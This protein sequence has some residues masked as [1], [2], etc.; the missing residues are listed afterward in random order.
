[1][2][3]STWLSLFAFAG[4]AAGIIC[5]GALILLV[6]LRRRTLGALLVRFGLR[7]FSPIGFFTIVILVFLIVSV[8]ESGQF[9]DRTITHHA[10]SGLLG[11]ALA[12]GF[13][14]I[15]VV[16]MQAR[17]NAVRMRDDRGQRLNLIGVII[18]ASVSAFAN[19]AGSVQGYRPVDLAQTP[20]WMR[21]L[22]PWLS[23]VFP[24][25]I[26][27][28]SLTLDHLLDHTP[29]RGIDVATFREREQRRVEILQVRLDTTR[30]L[31]ALE[32]E[33]AALRHQRERVGDG[34]ARE[35]FW[36]RWLRPRM[37][38]P[39]MSAS[40]TQEVQQA[41]H[42]A[43]RVLDAHLTECQTISSTLERQ[44]QHLTA[45]VQLIASS[46]E[47]QGRASVDQAMTRRATVAR[48][49]GHQPKS[50][51]E[52]LDQRDRS[53]EKTTQDGPSLAH[54][55]T[56][57]AQ[58]HLDQQ[59]SMSHQETTDQ[60]GQHGSSL[61]HAR[62]PLFE[63]EPSLDLDSGNGDQHHLA[64]LI[65]AALVRTPTGSDRLIAREVGCSKS[66]V[67]RWRRRFAGESHRRQAPPVPSQAET[68][69]ETAES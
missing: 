62:P 7:L 22:A 54:P 69:S 27:V 61:D 32:T 26:V 57:M 29:A 49:P 68:A 28:L 39:P 30:A 5:A 65:Q 50:D 42:A 64:H 9:F 58:V 2:N 52:P 40:V 33:L 51:Q 67:A 35:W 43:Q 31:L 34:V 12:L 38:T 63:E 3:W 36:M 21:L 55:H 20:E 53:Q 47:D 25:M 19:A 16:C 37:A 11:Y 24:A 13:D 10:I 66:T 56:P 6:V 4:I 41:I 1:M 15:S 46:T 17:L 59:G 8:L 18:C 45:L 60:V 23:M 48:R 44:M 14:L